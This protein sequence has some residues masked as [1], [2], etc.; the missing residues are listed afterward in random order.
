MDELDQYDPVVGR[1][2]GIGQLQFVDGSS[3]VFFEARQ[4]EDSRIVIGCFAP[5]GT[6]GLDPRALSGVTTT[7]ESLPTD[8][9]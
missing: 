8:G 6:L 5:S 2:Q 7:D 3:P 4:V 9:C 1:Y